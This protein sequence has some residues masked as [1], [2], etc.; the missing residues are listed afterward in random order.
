MRRLLAMCQRLKL[1]Q[2]QKNNKIDTKNVD[3]EMTS[4]MA[5]G[6]NFKL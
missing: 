1:S 6:I 5:D 3:H 4:V 2:K